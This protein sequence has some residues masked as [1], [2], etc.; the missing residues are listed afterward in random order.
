MGRKEGHSSEGRLQTKG[1]QSQKTPHTLAGLVMSLRVGH[2]PFA[3]NRE[4]EGQ[5]PLWEVWSRGP[6]RI[7][8]LSKQASWQQLDS[9]SCFSGGCLNMNELCSIGAVCK[10]TLK[11]DFPVQEYSWC[12]RKSESSFK[13]PCKRTRWIKVKRGV[14]LPLQ[15]SSRRKKTVQTPSSL[16]E[17]LKISLT[18]GHDT[19][20]CRKRYIRKFLVRVEFPC[21]CYI[22]IVLFTVDF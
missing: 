7:P 17:K 4:R 12:R 2:N 20:Q 9:A 13:V 16:C 22:A 21:P 6:Q 5:K 11:F 8:Q 18:K 1:S 19:R 3:G 10:F 14:P 15:V